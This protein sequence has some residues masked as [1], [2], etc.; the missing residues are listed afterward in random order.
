M[1]EAD[2]TVMGVYLDCMCGKRGVDADT[3]SLVRCF[4]WYVS[5]SKSA[6]VFR[7]PLGELNLNIHVPLG[8]GDLLLPSHRI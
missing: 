7:Q 2:A 5:Y 4:N 8:V 6:W 1:G 3:A